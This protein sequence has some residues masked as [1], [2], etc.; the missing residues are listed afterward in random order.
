MRRAWTRIINHHTRGDDQ[1]SGDD[2]TS[3]RGSQDS[4]VE[5]FICNELVDLTYAT[6]CI[7]MCSF[8]CKTCTTRWVESKLEENKIVLP[9]MKCPYG[10]YMSQ[11]S[12]CKT[13]TTSLRTK[14]EEDAE[15]DVNLL[16][17]GS[18]PV[19]DQRW[20][21]NNSKPCPNCTVPI[22][23]NGGCDI[24]NCRVCNHRFL[25]STGQSLS[26]RWNPPP[27]LRPRINNQKYPPTNQENRN[28]R[29]T[30]PPPP[31]PSPPRR[32][33]RPDYEFV[34]G[35]MS[36]A[37]FIFIVVRVAEWLLDDA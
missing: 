26:L 10:H 16:V 5:C 37:I 8:T 4:H 2:S 1:R 36:K 28:T 24:M 23:K 12:V 22:E 25:W 20:I 31:P 34:A 6:S 30:P 18:R 32:H 7:D 27:L 14:V 35:V 9:E 17:G 21:D 13:L 3:V 33:S 11:S 15:D 29:R 19:R